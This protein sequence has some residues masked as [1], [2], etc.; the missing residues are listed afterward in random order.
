[1]RAMSSAAAS[2]DA[3]QRLELRVADRFEDAG[4]D[5]LALAADGAVERAA[6]VVEQLGRDERARVPSREDE[7]AR[8]APLGLDRQVD[9]LGR[10]RQV[11]QREAHGVGPE[12]LE[13]A[14]VVTVAEDLQVE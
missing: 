9:H 5:R 14:E 10:V 4:R 3:G 2:G 13:L 7:A 11:V 12:R 8:A 6:R 1:M